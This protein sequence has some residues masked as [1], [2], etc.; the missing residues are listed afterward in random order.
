VGQKLFVVNNGSKVRQQ[1]TCDSPVNNSQ[2]QSDI[3][4]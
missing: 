1:K 4:N 3:T 2:I